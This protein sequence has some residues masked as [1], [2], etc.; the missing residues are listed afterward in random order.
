LL[1]DVNVNISLTRASHR[2]S[3]FYK[4]TEAATDPHLNPKVK[5]LDASL[6]VRKHTPYPSIVLSHQKL[7]D[8]G[9][10][11]RYPLKR[12]EAKF[13][14]I[15]QRNQSFVEENV[16]MGSIPSRILI[17]LVPN[18]SFDGTYDSNPFVF[19][20]HN[21]NYLSVNVNN[22]P[23]PVKALSLDFSSNQ[24]SLSYYL[25]MSGLGI[26]GKDH[27][28]CFDRTKFLE[29][30]IFFA[31]DINQSEGSE[32][33]LQLEKSGSVRIELK[34]ASALSHALNCIVYSENQALIE[35]DKFRRASYM[36]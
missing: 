28:L 31:F 1:N 22:I 26:A 20:H 7:L 11:A 19:S 25:L 13:F 21:L 29:G 4:H 5:F 15:P 10:N 18:S 14:T 16:F 24:Y 12:S 6:F 35:L 27:G 30:N 8:S 32:S 36:Q 33:T 2:F 3:L 23:V 9:H 17:A 34:F